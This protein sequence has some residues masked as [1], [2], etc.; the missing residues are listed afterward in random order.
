RSEFLGGALCLDFL[1]TVHDTGADD[2]EEELLSDAHFVIWTV[3]A[4]ILSADEASGLQARTLHKHVQLKLP[5]KKPAS[6]CDNARVL[7][8]SLRQMFQR[9]LRDG[10]VA[11]Q[12][13]EKLNLLLER[14]PAT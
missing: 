6:L 4:G 3:H 7:R 14:F 8:E 10:Q 13:V 2:P 11:P 12:D 5:G 9:A 1:N